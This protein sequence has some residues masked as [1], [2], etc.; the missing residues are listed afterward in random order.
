MSA[1]DYVDHL[2]T[3]SAYLQLP[4]SEQEQVYDRIMRVLPERVEVAADVIVHLA[5]RSFEH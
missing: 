1:R 3:V 4:S 5:R 2:S